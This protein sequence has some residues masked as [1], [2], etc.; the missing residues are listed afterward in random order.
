MVGSFGLRT[1]DLRGRALDVVETKRN[2]TNPYVAKQRALPYAKRIGAPF[3]FLANGDLI[4]FWDYQNDYACILE[5]CLHRDL[6]YLVP[7]RRHD[8][9]SPLISDQAA[10]FTPRRP[11]ISRHAGH[12]F[13]RMAATDF[14]V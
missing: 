9:I 8:V 3:I 1:A 10:Y 7:L 5:P 12:P 6:E 11:L 13:H 4:Y 14:T 2:A